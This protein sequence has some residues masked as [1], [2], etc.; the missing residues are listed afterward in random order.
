MWQRIRQPQVSSRS[1]AFASA[2]HDVFMQA[3]Q[4]TVLSNSLTSHVNGPAN[5][6]SGQGRGSTPGEAARGEQR[7]END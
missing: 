6:T 5:G 2:Q 1:Q 7:G 3:M 4:G